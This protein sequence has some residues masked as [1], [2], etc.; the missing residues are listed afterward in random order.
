[1]EK[2]RMRTEGKG[3]F[4]GQ[5]WRNVLVALCAVW[6]CLFSVCCVPPF[7]LPLPSFCCSPT[8]KT[9]FLFLPGCRQGGQHSPEGLGTL[10]TVH[11][12]PQYD[13]QV[14]FCPSPHFQS[15]HVHYVC[16]HVTLSASRR[17][18]VTAARMM[19]H[20]HFLL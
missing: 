11:K 12:H 2:V 20:Y 15:T 1:M 10:L 19:T 9:L 3:Q 5:E 13:W 8:L 7:L 17:T 14:T 16:L 6:P 4:H 18:R